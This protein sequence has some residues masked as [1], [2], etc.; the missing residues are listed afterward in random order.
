[1]PIINWADPL[2]RLRLLDSIGPAAYNA[3]IERHFVEE[4]VE[5]CNGYRLRRV[6]SR[7]GALIS[8]DGTGKAYRDVGAAREVARGLEPGNFALA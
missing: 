4:T 7:F 1:M 6:A 2:A 8:I 3:A 5:I